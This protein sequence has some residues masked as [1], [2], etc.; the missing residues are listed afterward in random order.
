MEINILDHLK[1]RH[2]DVNLYK[3]IFI[4][5]SLNCIYF[6]IYNISGKFLGYQCYTPEKPKRNNQ[7]DDAERR[8]NTEVTEVNKITEIAY[9]GL[10]LLNPKDV[11][12]FLVEGIFDAC[13]LHNLGLNSLALLSSDVY[14]YREHLQSLGYNLIPVCEGDEAGLKLMKLG[15]CNEIIYLGNT[16]DLGDL[17]DEE[18]YEIF[19]HYL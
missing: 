14:R 8:Y 17:S 18:I 16:L 3:D 1:K 2:F 10:E 4:P 15:N 5:N 12:I 7:L 9:F 11:N 19:K 6:Y 13:R